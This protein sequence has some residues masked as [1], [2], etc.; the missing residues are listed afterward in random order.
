M[1]FREEDIPYGTPLSDSLFQASLPQRRCAACQ[2]LVARRKPRV[3][4]RAS[5]RDQDETICPACWR[6]ICAW[7][8]RFALQ[9]IRLPE[10]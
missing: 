4:L 6:T 3:T 10:A 7:A 2:A 1:T 9:Q 5:W 8:A